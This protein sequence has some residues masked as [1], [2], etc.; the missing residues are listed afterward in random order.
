[1]ART[2]RFSQNIC[3][4]EPILA[5][6]IVS[7]SDH[8]SHFTEQIAQQASLSTYD[9][10][11]SPSTEQES[12]NMSNLLLSNTVDTSLSTIPPES[13]YG[14]VDR[15]ISLDPSNVQ[16]DD[17]ITPDLSYSQVD[18]AVVTVGGERAGVTDRPGG[19]DSVDA[20]VVDT[21]DIIERANSIGRT[22]NINRT[23]NSNSSQSQSPWNHLNLSEIVNNRVIG[24]TGGPDVT[25]INRTSTE[26]NPIKVRVLN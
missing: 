14:Q 7:S 8:L 5:G 25:Q 21:T 4:T 11:H 1:M 10:P 23:N 26:A 20:D 12:D 9:P 6:N 24:V 22:A 3:C 16:V 13:A 15:N 18:T 19:I 2:T 17:I